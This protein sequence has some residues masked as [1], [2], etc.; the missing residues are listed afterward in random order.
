MLS[1]GLLDKNPHSVRSCSSHQAI[2]KADLSVK[3]LST[4][5]WP[6]TASPGGFRLG[7]LFRS[8]RRISRV[9]I[10]S[11]CSRGCH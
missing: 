4:L 11:P 5:I 8:H 6:S 1:V 10:A 7:W 3:T 2:R 9:T